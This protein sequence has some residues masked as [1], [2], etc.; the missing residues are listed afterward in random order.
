MTEPRRSLPTALAAGAGWAAS[1]GSIPG[2][3]HAGQLPGGRV[4]F[5]CPCLRQSS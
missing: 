3:R 1:A 4:A 5:F 2:A